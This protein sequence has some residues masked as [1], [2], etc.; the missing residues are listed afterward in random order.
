MDEVTTYLLPFKNPEQLENAVDKIK[1]AWREQGIV[2]REELR[3]K[4][5][6]YGEIGDY[7]FSVD[8]DLIPKSVDVAKVMD[9]FRNN[10]IIDACHKELN[11]E[12]LITK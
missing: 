1:E 10:P 5:I 7:G 3:K 8:I 2:H 11:V 6:Q 4:N 9:S 12:I